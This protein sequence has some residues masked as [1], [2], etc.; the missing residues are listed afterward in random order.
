M[1]AQKLS[2]NPLIP[3]DPVSHVLNQIVH[4]FNLAERR[5][6]E[7]IVQLNPLNRL[8]MVM[9]VA[10]GAAKRDEMVRQMLAT[11]GVLQELKRMAMERKAEQDE[12]S[13]AEG[14][15]QASRT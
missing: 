2:I 7:S 8:M 11:P 10:T 9:S 5:Q 12:A 13:A 3:I 6:I 1:E 15:S 4:R 14:V